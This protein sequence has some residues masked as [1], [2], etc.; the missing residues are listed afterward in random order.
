MSNK[1]ALDNKYWNEY[2]NKSSLAG[3]TLDANISR[4]DFEV[5]GN[6]LA[7][8]QIEMM[9]E[10][11][12]GN[13]KDASV[14]DVGCGMGRV[15][16]PY[17]NFFAKVYGIDINAKI[18]E[19]AR[20]FAGPRPNLEFIQ[21]DGR[22]LPFKDNELDIAYS[23]GVLQ[24]I[25]EI[26]IITNYFREGLRVIKPGG[27]LNFSIQVWMI[28]RKGGVQGD[29]VGA[30]IRATDIEK[31]L[32]DTGHDLVAMYFDDIDPVP[33]YN[34][35]IKKLSDEDAQKNIESR[36]A[37]PYKIDPKMVQ[38]KKIRTGIFEDLETYTI[39]RDLWAKKRSK[40]ITFFKHSPAVTLGYLSKAITNKVLK[41]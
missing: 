1:E 3:I 11:Y 40:N 32:N 20:E 2:K 7:E 4:E 21:N 38:I 14:V 17:S 23:G 39:F 16:K 8:R 12:E 29:R 26:D 25:P 30:Q 35:I 34:I 13:L 28:L 37:N 10:H 22:T 27:I 9:T 15:S 18:L 5:Y 36:K 41:R 19:A 24:H 31:I 6:R 33:N